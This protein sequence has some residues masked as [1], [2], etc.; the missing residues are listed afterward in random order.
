[1]TGTARYRQTE[2]KGYVG[3]ND[4][5]IYGPCV[6]RFTRA[7]AEALG[8]RVPAQLVL[9]AT[10]EQ[11]VEALIAD[12]QLI[13]DQERQIHAEEAGQV[14][15]AHSILCRMKSAER[16][17]ALVANNS[18]ARSRKT[19]DTFRK[20]LSLGNADYPAEVPVFHVSAG[21]TTEKRIESVEAFKSTPSAIMC[22]ARCLTEGF[23]C[24][25]L[26]LVALLDPRQA[27]GSIGATWVPWTV[28]RFREQD[29]LASSLTHS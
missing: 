7:E 4:A 19:A 12:K 21:M 14:A 3:M 18:V 23:N 22:V 8:M 2:L 28:L 25:D 17:K 29:L 24:P 5:D 10:R 27:S 26:D 15:A 20:L 13:T 1:M 16:R 6:G 11:S 9:L